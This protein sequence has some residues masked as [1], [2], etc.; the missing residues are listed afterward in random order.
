M[1]GLFYEIGFAGKN[2]ILRIGDVEEI[3]EQLADINDWMCL[4]VMGQ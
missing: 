4:V 1:I 3:R 2:Y